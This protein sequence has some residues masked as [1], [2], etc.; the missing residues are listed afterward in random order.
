MGASLS[1]SRTTGMA[2][3]TVDVGDFV[4]LLSRAE[5]QSLLKA[6]CDQLEV[7]DLVSAVMEQ[8]GQVLLSLVTEIARCQMVEPIVESL[9]AGFSL[10]ECETAGALL[11]AGG[12][13]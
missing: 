9:Q 10:T 1:L 2:N 3:L 7:A 5:Q 12:A 11:T 13:V 8:D 4:V 6:L